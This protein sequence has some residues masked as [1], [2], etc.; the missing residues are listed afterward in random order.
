M[1][2]VRPG[3]QIH[4]SPEHGDTVAGSAPGG[5]LEPL[6]RTFGGV[7]GTGS[8]ENRGSGGNEPENSFQGQD[9]KQELWDGGS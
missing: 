1:P 2:G 4:M 9:T 8:R 7:M 3:H 6:M 5:D